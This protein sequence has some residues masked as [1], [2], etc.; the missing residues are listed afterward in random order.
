MR[1]P[2][3]GEHFLPNGRDFQVA[4]KTAL[5]AL[6]YSP[7]STEN[8]V[9]VGYLTPMKLTQTAWNVDGQ[10][11]DFAFGTQRNLFYTDSRWEFCVRGDV[12]ILSL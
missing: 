1:P 2:E 8:C 6:L 12:K 3:G 9:C 5:L 11:E 7:Y 10:R 4:Q